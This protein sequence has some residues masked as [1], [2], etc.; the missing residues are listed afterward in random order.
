MGAGS[1]RQWDKEA[2]TACIN[3]TAEL[4][5]LKLRDIMPLMFAAVTGQASSVLV[6]WMHGN[7]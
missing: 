3:S 5:E 6:S 7:F 2:I 1:S 4:L